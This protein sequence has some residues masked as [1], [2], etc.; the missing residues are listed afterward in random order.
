MIV[1]PEVDQARGGAVDLHRPRPPLAGDR[2]GLEAR[3]VVDVEHV[4]LLVLEDVGRAQQI[5]VD[6]D[7][8]DVVQVAVGDRRPVDLGL[9]HHAL[10]LTSTFLGGG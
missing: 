3:A 9:E 5:R 4:H 6:R 1:S 8:A 7:R 10:H 2:V